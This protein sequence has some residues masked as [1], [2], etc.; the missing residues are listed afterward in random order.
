MPVIKA[1]KDKGAWKNVALEGLKMEEWAEIGSFEEWIP[2]AE[3]GDD[4]ADEGQ[5][6]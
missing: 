6:R 3:E 2:G 4:G 5:V 1:S